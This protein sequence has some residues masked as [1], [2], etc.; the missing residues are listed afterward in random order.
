[1]HRQMANQM[2]AMFCFVV[3]GPGLRLS[4]SEVKL[5]K[6]FGIPR[7]TTNMGNLELKSKEAR[8]QGWQRQGEKNNNKEWGCAAPLEDMVG[9]NHLTRNLSVWVSPNH[10]NQNIR[11]KVLCHVNLYYCMIHH[12]NRILF[13]M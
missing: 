2:W 3:T 7:K 1:M 4:L 8:P 9:Q 10:T 11:K 12:I 6:D 5:Q 13:N